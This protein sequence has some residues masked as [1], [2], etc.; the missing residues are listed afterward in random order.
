LVRGIGCILRQFG[1]AH[2]QSNPGQPA[3]HI[4]RTQSRQH[5]QMA[6]LDAVH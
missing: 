3:I 4:A 5:L 2:R 1:F 6:E